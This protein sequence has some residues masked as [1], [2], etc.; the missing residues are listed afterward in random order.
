MNSVYDYIS[1]NLDIIESNSLAFPF[2]DFGFLYGYGL[3]ESIKVC[4]S[5]YDNLK[6][7]YKYDSN[8][9]SLLPKLEDNTKLIKLRD[10]FEETFNMDYLRGIVFKNNDRVIILEDD[11]I[12]NYS[13]FKFSN[14]I[15]EKYKDDN[16]ISQVSGNNFLNFKKFKRRNRDSYF[17]ST[18]TSSWGW[19]TW[20]NRWSNYYDKDVK[21]WPLIKNQSWLNDILHNDKSVKFWKKAFE[22]RYKG[23]DDDWDRPWTFVNFINE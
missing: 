21:M 10:Y 13:F 22:R 8:S 11:C 1:K 17:F 20:R 5:L 2:L 6:G 15:L 4:I 18:L 14:L 7:V 9:S 23:L 19:A 16:R 3:F 12:P